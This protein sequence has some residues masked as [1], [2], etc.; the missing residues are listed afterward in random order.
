MSIDAGPADDH[1]SDATDAD[2]DTRVRVVRTVLHSAL[3]QLRLEGAIFFRSELTEPFA[4]ES[5]PNMVAPALHPGAERIILFHIVARGS[6][7][8]AAADGVRHWASRGDVMVLP[9]G[10]P[11]TIGGEAPASCVSM[12]QLLDPPPWAEMPVVHHGGGGSETDLVCGYLYSGDPLFDPAL[13]AFPQAFVVRLPDGAAAADQGWIAALSDP[14]LAL[15]R[16]PR[17]GRRFARR[18]RT[19]TRCLRRRAGSSGPA[20]RAARA[21]GRS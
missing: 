12:L 6:C 21:L 11:H 15:A 8:V 20:R 13:R 1:D 9:Y 14:V 7:W 18:T 19:A 16:R 10:D 3:E 17:G 5:T 4:F 2:S